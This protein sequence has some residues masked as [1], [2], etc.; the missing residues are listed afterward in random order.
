MKHPVLKWAGMA[1]W[2]VSA[3][4]TINVGLVPFNVNFFT[5]DFYMSNIAY[6]R[7]EMPLFYLILA[8]GLYSGVLLVMAAMGMCGCGSPKGKCK[9]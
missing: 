3:L 5:S 4:V 9:C 8:S 7:L 2:V 6:S 1:A